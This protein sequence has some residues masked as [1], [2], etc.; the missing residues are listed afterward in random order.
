MT[1]PELN[2]STGM[3]LLLGAV[4]GINPAMGWL[5]AVSLGLQERCGSA[6]WRALGPLACGHALAIAATLLAAGLVGLVVPPGVMRWIAAAA[7]LAFG[8]RSLVR[9]RHPG[10][11][12]MRVGS[13]ELTAWSFL[14]ASAHG[15]G[16]MV[17]PF[18]L[19]LVG[20]GTR[21]DVI[22]GAHA[23]G[24]M[25]EAAAATLGG[26]ASTGTIADPALLVAT[27]LHT[28]GYLLA[29]GAVAWLVYDRLG[30]RVL[31]TAWININLVWAIA[32]IMTALLTPLL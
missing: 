5:F 23:H 14:M 13:R 22:H 28:V 18:A 1:M 29:A 24:P 16:L 25:P 10:L 4:H 31:R 12:G 11:A 2:A 8:V 9:H 3:I 15:A 32:L 6:T 26:A 17:L 27:V 20:T 7:L 19:R 30:V 21:H